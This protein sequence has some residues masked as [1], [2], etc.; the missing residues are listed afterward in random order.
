MWL[1]RK[2]NSLKAN[3]NWLQNCQKDKRS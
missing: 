2:A 1:L 3:W